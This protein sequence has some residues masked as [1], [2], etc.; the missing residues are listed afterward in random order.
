VGVDIVPPTADL[1][2]YRLVIAPALHVLDQATADNLRH[3]V[4]NGGTLLTTARS[5]VKDETNAVVNVPLPGLLA[6]VC[7]VEVDEYDVLPS[8]VNVPLEL[9]MPE[10][11]LDA[12]ARLWCDVL[13]PTTAQTVGRYQGEYYAGRA[14]VTLNHFGQ[15]Q[16]VYVG[17]LGNAAL[18]NAVIGWL[19]DAARV[20]PVLSTP[21]G[22]EAVERWKGDRRLL[23]LL[24][25]ADQAQDVALS[26]PLT[27]LLTGRVVEQRVTLEP[28]AVMIL[29]EV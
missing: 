10:P 25:H 20:S 5:G 26:R 21:D 6:E 18:H 7:G 11:A 27:D 3:Y 9:E 15:G 24:N 1:S 16:A 8:D 14:A 2:P 28:K 22:V 13:T 29:R 19:V 23:F 12:Y 4:E 17:T